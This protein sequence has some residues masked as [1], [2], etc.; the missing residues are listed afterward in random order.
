MENHGKPTYPWIRKA[1]NLCVNLAPLS[2]APFVDGLLFA[3]DYESEN[4]SGVQIEGTYISICI[5]ET[6]V[7]LVPLSVHGEQR[8]S[9]SHFDDHSIHAH[10]C[11]NFAQGHIDC[12]RR[13]GR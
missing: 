11:C 4:T 10:R 13:K 8:Y 1:I 9:S 5:H 2:T 6:R 3:N 7:H 12:E